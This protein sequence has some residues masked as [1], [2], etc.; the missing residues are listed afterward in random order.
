MSGTTIKKC[1]NCNHQVEPTH[2][3]ACP[4]C[5]KEAGYDITVTVNEV[6][7]VDDIVQSY[8]NSM[9]D[10]INDAVQ[11]YDNLA[12]KYKNNVIVLNRITNL[13][14]GL[15]SQQPELM[16][17]AEND[18]REEAKKPK[19]FTVD[20]II[21]TEEQRKEHIEKSVKS[22]IKAES[23]K[24]VKDLIEEVILGQEL[25]NTN[26]QKIYDRLSPK[27]TIF[28]SLGVGVLGSIIASFI[29]IMLT[30]DSSHI[31][32]EISTNMTNGTQP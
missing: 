25:A 9:E 21:G 8:R 32:V 20:A 6:V 30:G 1:K 14:N 7:K 24:T 3:G 15:I 29:V 22:E 28:V 12:K 17:T 27:Q 5:G 2:T 19:T 10:A 16:K 13:K 23:E 31:P 18:A 11:K 4:N 26:I